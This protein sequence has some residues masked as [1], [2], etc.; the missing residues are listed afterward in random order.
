MAQKMEMALFQS[1]EGSMVSDDGQLFMLHVKRPAGGDLLLGFPHTE[2]SNIVEHASIQ[3][4]H[5][6]DAEGRRTVAAFKT[7]HFRLGR[8]PDGEH[9]LTIMVG[10]AGMIS[11][12]LPDDMPA[13]L[14]GTLQKLA[15]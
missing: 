13:Q 3:A 14:S 5:G 15:N 12:L 9:I 11:F 8:G 2:I 10:K 6:R 7:S 1:V 4:R